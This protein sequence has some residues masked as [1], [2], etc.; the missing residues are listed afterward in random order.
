M[1]SV[2]LDS[3]FQNTTYAEVWEGIDREWI[4]SKTYYQVKRKILFFDLSNLFLGKV[5]ESLR[6]LPATI[7]LDLLL[8]TAGLQGKKRDTRAGKKEQDQ[9]RQGAR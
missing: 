4:Y 2:I 6:G 9:Q 1:E 8:R 7:P 3:Y 5:P